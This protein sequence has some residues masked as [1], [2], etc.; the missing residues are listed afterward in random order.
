MESKLRYGKYYMDSNF[1]C[2]KENGHPVTPN[3]VKYSCTRIQKQLGFPFNFHSLRHTHAT[4]L[5]ENGANIKEIQAR[6]GHS[7]I[8]TT[9]DT[10]SHVTHKMKQEIVDIFERMI[11]Q[12]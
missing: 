5:L 2:T 1:V 11:H 12:N 6:L 10:Y 7:R 3:S 4:M 8:S 9:M